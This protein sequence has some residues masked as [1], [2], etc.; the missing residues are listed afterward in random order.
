MV[1]TDVGFIA[2]WAITVLHLIPAQYLYRDYTNPLLVAWNWSF[3][4]LDLLIS[5]TGLT[6]WWL[7]RRGDALWLPTV[8]ISLALTVCSG[9]QAIAFWA[10]R[11]D[12]AADWW[13]VNGFLLVYPLCFAPALLSELR[14]RLTHAG[15]KRS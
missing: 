2:Y 8:L 10:M 9:L 11:G 1:A 5:A 3:L 14:G 7:H 6:G 12:F 4:P 13:L 15:N